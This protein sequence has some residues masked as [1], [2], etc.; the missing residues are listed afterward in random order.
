MIFHRPE[1][2][3]PPPRLTPEIQ[4]RASD[5]KPTGILLGQ[6]TH[7]DPHRLPNPHV[8][9]IGASGSGKTQT[10]KAMAYEL[11]NYGRKQILIIDFHGDQSLPDEVVYP[12]HMAS[13]HGIN[14]LT[15]NPDPE[16]GG[17]HLQAIQVAMLIRKTLTLGPIQEGHLLET[18]KEIYLRSGILQSQPG[19]WQQDPPTFA[20]LEK[21]I[22]EHVEAGSTDYAKLQI[23]LAATFSY[24]IFSRP[25][26]S[27]WVSNLIRIDVSK[28]PPALGS[29]AAESLAHQLM[30]QHRLLGESAP[31][32]FLFIDE[33]K[34]MPK[35][36]GSALDRII[37]DGRKYGLALILASQSE[38]HLSKDVIA[39]SA[40][41]IVL[42]VD[43][44][45]VKTVARKFRF[46]EHL[47]A[48]L[49]PLSALVRLGSQAA[50]VDILPYYHR[51]EAPQNP[52]LAPQ[53][54]ETDPQPQAN[55]KEDP[56]LQNPGRASP[57]LDI[58]AKTNLHQRMDRPNL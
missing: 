19:T 14:P 50:Q 58:Q 51:V 24:G 47:I 30:N 2:P 8:V 1:A 39:N 42:P 57:R 17:P 22:E 34:E 16:G 6:T 15:V 54:E 53:S 32:T 36:S 43:Q 25:Q 40:T 49:R 45:E 3:L 56:G 13:P 5:L 52:I 12:L 46:A 11:A 27:L 44:T 29:I 26:P 18:L 23:K 4:A 10:L 35:T 9:V 38:R 41:K 7:W 31:K 21:A 28:L 37:M 55:P 48:Q 33:A 20:D